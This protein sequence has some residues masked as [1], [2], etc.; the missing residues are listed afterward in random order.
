[1]LVQPL[2]PDRVGNR[3]H[4]E[5]AM[6]GSGFVGGLV[7]GMQQAQD[8]QMQMAHLKLQ[9]DFAKYQQK[10]METQDQLQQFQVQALQ[11]KIEAQAQLPGM[12]TD[13]LGP[14]QAR[15]LGP[16]EEGPAPDVAPGRIQ[17]DIGRLMQ[18]AEMAGYDS[19]KL[20]NFASLQDPTGTIKG[21]ME[22]RQ[23]EKILEVE[24]GKSV[25]GIRPGMKEARP[26]FQAPGKQ[27][28]SSVAESKV[29]AELASMF[30][31]KMATL[32]QE[33]GR[34]PNF[35]EAGQF[36]SPSEFSQSFRAKEERT[37]AGQVE[38][39]QQTGVA[40]QERAFELAQKKEK[41]PQKPSA[42]ERH[43]FAGDLV[44]LEQAQGII[45]KFDPKFVGP[46]WGRY[47]NVKEMIGNMGFDEAEFRGTVARTRNA[48]IK[49]ITGAQMSETEATRIRQELPEFNLS[50]EAFIARMQLTYANLYDMAR[51]RRQ[52][53]S[54]TGL[55]LAD[56]KPLVTPKELDP[57]IREA[58]RQQ[59]GVTPVGKAQE[60]T[61]Q[62]TIKQ[63]EA[64][65]LNSLSKD[66]RPRYQQLS[67]SDRAKFRERYARKLHDLPQG[68][69]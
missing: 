38:V 65:F 57:K 58:L 54:E 2:R 30:P 9:Q 44:A 49:A 53:A 68:T 29:V 5:R 67:P 22:S 41:I 39:A 51:I 27:E 34:P 20:L 11:K 37:R 45:E 28:K 62:G 55:D 50:P 46:Y 10:T 64:A 60:R 47:G 35:M 33:L 25:I 52:I 19:E 6:G 4:K 17:G 16:G 24:P 61:K 13:L 12:Q 7:Q 26:I 40:A 43:D 32:Q 59:A 48:A 69:R 15:P 3:R 14:L 21:M 18:V 31:E 8:R 66:M 42:G 1:M 56:L 23:P 36:F 63:D